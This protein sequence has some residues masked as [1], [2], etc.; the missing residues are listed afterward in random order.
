MDSQP[1]DFSKLRFDLYP[2]DFMYLAHTDDQNQWQSGGIVPFQELRLSPAAAVFNYGQ[3][4]FEG[5]KAFHT[6]K[7]EVVLFRPELNARRFQRS[8]AR[9]LMPVFP[10]E[11]FLDAVAQTVRANRRWIPPYDSERGLQSPCSLYI[12][13]LM[14]GSGAV[15]GVRPAPSYTMVVFVSPVGP[16]LPGEGRV[17]VLDDYHR[18]PPGGTGSVKA[19]GNYAGTLLPHQ[20]AVEGGF[21][22]ALYLDAAEN[23]HIE[24]LGSS[25]FFA[26]FPGSRL[27]TPPLSGTILP[28]VTRD[29]ILHI[30]RS[31]NWTVEERPLSIQEVLQSAE[32]AF[33]TGTAAVVQSINEIHFQGESCPI[34][35]PGEGQH[36]R[37]LRET[38]VGIQ[39]GQLPDSWGWLHK[40]V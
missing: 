9:L 19:A 36:T 11:Q 2:T 6:A 24:E 20:T 38:L 4:V 37:K 40:V 33:F 8:C 15:L 32:E 13:P 39:T 27:V 30:A 22:D 7:D 28:G 5:M 23:Q 35:L 26:V 12:R 29:S 14:L 10:E 16:Y 34:G 18:T 21:K 31:L 3:A 17:V 1:M 25:N